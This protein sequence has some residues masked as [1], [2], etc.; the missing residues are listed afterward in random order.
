MK[1]KEEFRLQPSYQETFKRK[2]VKEI[3]TGKYTKKESM[4]IYNLSWMTIQR[5]LN[6]FGGSVILEEGIE[7]INLKKYNM[8]K[9]NKITESQ[10]VSE[11][12]KRVREL[13][14]R[15]QE[16]ELKAELSEKIIDIAE[17]Q[18]KIP[19]RKKYVTRQ[20]PGSKKAK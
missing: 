16:A 6:K 7:T 9:K 13:E 19:I 20:S 12:R 11:L 3:I 5:W 2:V 1:T 17:E 18:F 15:L 4:E 8:S 14:T 10:K